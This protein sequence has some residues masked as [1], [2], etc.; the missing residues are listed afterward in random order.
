[1]TGRGSNGGGAFFF[2]ILTASLPI[3][4]K[5]TG[6][7]ANRD[8]ITPLLSFSRA[9]SELTGIY[10]EFSFATCDIKLFLIGCSDLFQI[11]F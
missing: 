11:W 1:M 2:K 7:K 3:K 8:L 10:F 9:A 6:K 4:G 5:K